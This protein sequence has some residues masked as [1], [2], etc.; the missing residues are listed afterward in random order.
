[1]SDTT[2][3]QPLGWLTVAKSKHEFKTDCNLKLL[4]NNSV[5]EIS[6]SR[7]FKHQ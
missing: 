7:F 6:G 3:Q 5:I 1:M 2:V 4:I